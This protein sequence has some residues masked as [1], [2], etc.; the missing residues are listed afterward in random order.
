MDYYYKKTWRGMV[1]M[2]SYQEYTDFKIHT[3][4]RKATEREAQEFLTQLPK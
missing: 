4:Y 3:K 1:L 2:I